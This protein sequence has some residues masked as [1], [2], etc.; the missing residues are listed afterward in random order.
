M[1]VG[2]WSE[3][4]LV[5][6]P[7]TGVIESVATTRRAATL[8]SERWPVVYGSAYTLAVQTCADV[9]IGQAPSYVARRAFVEAAKEI[10]IA[11]SY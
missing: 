5:R 10:G 8:L 1:N 3:A 4:V 6:L 7:D 2:P 11:V 9:L